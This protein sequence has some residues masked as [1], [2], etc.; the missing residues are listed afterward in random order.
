MG[1][2]V[3]G[4]KIGAYIAEIVMAS[5]VI[6]ELVGMNYDK[7]QDVIITILEVATSVLKGIKK[8]RSLFVKSKK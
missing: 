8:L 3:E 1:K 7:T 6:I 4:L 5:A 2:L